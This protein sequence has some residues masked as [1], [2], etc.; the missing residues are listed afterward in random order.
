MHQTDIE[1]RVASHTAWLQGRP[2]GHRLEL[3]GVHLDGVKF[4]GAD[5]RRARLTGASLR[6]A[7]PHSSRATATKSSVLRMKVPVTATP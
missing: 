7:V 1:H 6:Q 2:G 5:L 4:H 3:H